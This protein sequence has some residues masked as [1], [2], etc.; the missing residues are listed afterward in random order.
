MKNTKMNSDKKI[1]V[2]V[3][4]DSKE[5]IATYVCIDSIME[6][7]NSEI[8]FNILNLNNLKSIFS[9]L[10]NKK[11]STEFAFSRFLVPYLSDY[12]GVSIFCDSDFLFL[13]N[14]ENLIKEVDTSKAV[15]VVQHDYIPKTKTK[16]LNQEQTVYPRKNWSSIMVFNNSLCN[17]L[18]PEIVNT[19]SGLY[20][21][22]FQWLED[23]QIGKLDRRWNHLV[24]EYE[25]RNKTEI[26]ALH[27]TIGGPYFKEYSKCSYADLWFSQLRKV[28]KPIDL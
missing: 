4:Y 17:Q 5:P 10:P 11:Q 12:Q 6:H 18:T 28:L 13:E 23:D 1:N 27:Y 15:S 21:H 24:D 22:R 7:T 25:Y 8:N 3:G 20:L 14:L 9:R 19:E 26:G 2:F 16:F